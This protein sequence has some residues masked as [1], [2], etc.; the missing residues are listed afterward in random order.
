MILLGVDPGPESSGVVLYDTV[1][2]YV[3]ASHAK[4][5]FRDLQRMLQ[6]AEHHAVVC[7]RTTAGPPST[8]VV[9]TTEIVG[10]VIQVCDGDTRPLRLM[11]RHEV[12]LALGCTARGS[13]D[14]LVREA[15]MALHGGGR[16]V[17]CGTAR[18]PGPLYGVTSHAWQALALCVVFTM[19]AHHAHDDR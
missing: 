13:K 7:E 16:A 1:G 15:V 9:R 4:V 14:A 11:P 17:A 12:L 8:A 18:A 6:D 2:R 19:G 3:V 5:A 10:R